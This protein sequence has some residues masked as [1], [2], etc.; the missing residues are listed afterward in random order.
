MNTHSMKNS[1]PH[2]L[3]RLMGKSLRVSTNG[4]IFQ[5]EALVGLPVSSGV[6]EGRAR[7]IFNME[8][9]DLEDLECISHLIY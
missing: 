2:V 8:D 7:V 1:L 6:I 4:K 9:A 3:S 5:P